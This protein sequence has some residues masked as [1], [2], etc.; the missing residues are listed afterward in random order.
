MLGLGPVGPVVQVAYL[1][2]WR[3]ALCSPQGVN[4]GFGDLVCPQFI[5][6]DLADLKEKRMERKCQSYGSKVEG[7]LEF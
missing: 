1:H 3:P 2:A 7:K 4:K 5:G 6:S